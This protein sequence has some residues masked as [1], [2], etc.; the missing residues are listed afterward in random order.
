MKRV[1]FLQNSGAGVACA[2]DVWM[3]NGAGVHDVQYILGCGGAHALV[4]AAP[5]LTIDNVRAAGLPVGNT[6]TPQ[7]PRLA[8]VEFAATQWSFAQRWNITTAGLFHAN[9][10]RFYRH[11]RITADFAQVDTDWREHVPADMFGDSYVEATPTLCRYC[12]GT[13]GAMICPCACTTPVHHECLMRWLSTS[14]R[15]TCEVCRGKYSFL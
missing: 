13:D 7:K 8:H 5:E 15:E 14:P 6:W 11:L 9:P 10:A 4:I 3:V 2:G 12:H 1:V